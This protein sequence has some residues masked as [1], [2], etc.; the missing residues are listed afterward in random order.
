LLC[1]AVALAIWAGGAL[2]TLAD[3]E[4]AKPPP[5][6]PAIPDAASQ[7]KAEKVVRQIYQKEFADRTAA[8][9]TRLMGLLAA[10][11]GKSDGDPAERFVLLRDVRELAIAAGNMSQAMGAVDSLDQL[12]QIDGPEMR[13]AVFTAV[14]PKLKGPELESGSDQGLG[15]LERLMD[16]SETAQASRLMPIVQASVHRGTD[17]VLKQRLKNDEL[18]MSEC[19]RGNA[20]LQRLKDAP[21]DPAANLAAGQ[22]RCLV[23]G[24]WEKGLPLLAK[25][26]DARLKA[27]ALLETSNPS[28]SAKQLQLANDWFDFSEKQTPLLKTKARQ[29]AGQWY[30][31]CVPQL[32]GLSQVMAQ[33]RLGELGVAEP[34]PARPNPTII[35]QQIASG[36]IVGITSKSEQ[37]HVI[38]PLKRGS[39]VILQYVDGLWKSFGHVAGQS[40]DVDVMERGEV[41]R[42]VIAD[43]SRPGQASSALAVVPGGT[44]R[45]PFA[46]VADRDI[47]NVVLRINDA[48]GDYASNP[49]HG[50]RYRL[51]IMRPG[52]APPATPVATATPTTRP[53]TAARAPAVDSSGPGW[54]NLLASVPLPA[55][56]AAEVDRDGEGIVIHN[57]GYLRVPL[58]MITEGS[59]ELQSTFTPLAGTP[60]GAQIIIPVGNSSC[61]LRLGANDNTRISIDWVGRK[62]GGTAGSGTRR[63][64]A[65]VTPGRPHV[66]DIRVLITNGRADIT[67]AIDQNPA[68][69]WN[70]PPSMLAS[71]AVRGPFKAGFGL[72]VANGKVL[73]STVRVHPLSGKLE[74]YLNDAAPDPTEEKPD[75]DSPGP[76]PSTQPTNPTTRAVPGKT[77]FEE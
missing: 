59:F 29:H 35:A 16:T 10:Q 42:L 47:Q 41:S 74:P 36:E 39:V 25:G 43:N 44:I 27:L 58:R 57:E 38:G 30:R 73:F 18:L 69:H 26:S 68:L 45:A 72:V 6:Q 54:V 46:W 34:A 60:N 51:K 3:D 76:R 4:P 12:F 50:V 2:V 32:T 37:G 15:L 9:M 56:R 22:Y 48:D 23:M 70:G 31:A 7:A 28:D 20:A 75:P 5:T 8:G 14:L 52:E 24:D 13:I 19:V 21:D 11:A 65:R 63:A 71:K 55:E 64:D 1:P 53:A 67:V 77:I 33:K 66:A 17:P 62:S 49:D 61:R 40:P